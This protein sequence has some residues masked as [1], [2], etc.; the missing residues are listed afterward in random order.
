MKDHQERL[1]RYTVHMDLARAVWLQGYSRVLLCF[2][3]IPE[4]EGGLWAIP[5]YVDTHG[6]KDG[7]WMSLGKCKPKEHTDEHTPPVTAGLGCEPRG[8]L[9]LPACHTEVVP[10]TLWI[11]QLLSLE[12]A[13]CQSIWHNVATTSRSPTLST[14]SRFGVVSI[15]DPDLDPGL[16]KELAHEMLASLWR[17]ETSPESPRYSLLLQKHLLPALLGI[18]NK[19]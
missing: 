6:V 18:N 8:H 9:V 5:V 4:V 3:G 17:L 7:V 19:V 1:G 2:I 15:L 12:K 13:R 14:A 10:S 11:M 16:S